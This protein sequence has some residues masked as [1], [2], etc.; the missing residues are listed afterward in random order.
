MFIL[1]VQDVQIADVPDRQHPDRST[2]QLFYRD[3][4][5]ELVR[6]FLPSQLKLAQ[7]LWRYFDEQGKNCL[8]VKAADRYS[9]WSELTIEPAELT[10]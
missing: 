8:I 10:I 1:S 5:Y 7:G 4:Q 9:V 6:N 3:R 2:A